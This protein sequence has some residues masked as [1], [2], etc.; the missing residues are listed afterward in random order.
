MHSF[1]SQ[2]FIVRLSDYLVEKKRRDHEREQTITYGEFDL[3]LAIWYAILFTA[4]LQ[5]RMLGIVSDQC[6]LVGMYLKEAL[7]LVRAT[8]SSTIADPAPKRD[9][10]K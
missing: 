5:V 7:D 8:I 3:I 4:Q 1:S 9:K 6:R 2:L 10:R